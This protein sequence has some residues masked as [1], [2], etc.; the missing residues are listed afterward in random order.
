MSN[1]TFRDQNTVTTI[2]AIRNQLAANIAI[3]LQID[4]PTTINT[5]RGVLK[6]WT[7]TT[8][9]KIRYFGIGIGGYANLTSEENIAQPYVPSPEN[10]DLYHPIPFRCVRTTAD[11]T[12]DEKAQ[13]RMRT[14]TTIDGV[15]YFQY[16]LKKIVFESSVA[17]T[18]KI[19][20]GVESEYTFTQANLTPSPVDLY[21][22]DLADTKNRIVAS[23]TGICRVT[24]KE[25]LEVCNA[26]YGGDIRRMRISEFGTYSGC[27]WGVNNKENPVNPTDASCV[28]K[29]AGYVQLCTHKC[30]LGQILS[31]E[32]DILIERKILEN[33]S[34]VVI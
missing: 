11:L 22:T 31:N 21:P 12:D 25:V 20:D 3:S 1:T 28:R 4:H 23:V 10:C 34:C 27:E 2:L 18:T 26:M 5:K 7:P 19:E 13:Y 14:K 15:E 16:W 32:E 9:P 8:F 24:G 17:R 33:S 29:E 6:D 30:T